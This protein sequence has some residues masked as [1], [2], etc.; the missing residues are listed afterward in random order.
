MRPLPVRLAI[1]VL[2]GLVVVGCGADDGGREAGRPSSG[3]PSTAPTTTRATPAFPPAPERL[4][5]VAEEFLAFVRSGDASDLPLGH[6]V[7]LL[8]GNRPVA[9][10]DGADLRDRR[11]WSVCPPEGYAERSCPLSAVAA[12]RADQGSLVFTTA[13]PEEPCTRGPAL[14]PPLRDTD[15]VTVLVERRTSCLDYLAVQLF[16][17]VGRVVGA[18]LVLGSP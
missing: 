10:R 2:L 3:S 15:F 14:P 6:R 9:T 12:F 5:R 13:V 8:L 4:R 17:D 11:S 16:V 18:N 7:A 1:A